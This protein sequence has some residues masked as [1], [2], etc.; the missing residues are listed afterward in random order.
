MPADIILRNDLSEMEVEERA[1][2]SSEAER[3]SIDC[4]LPE[5]TIGLEPSI[6]QQIGKGRVKWSKNRL[7]AQDR[8]KTN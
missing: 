3:E 7:P 6:H 5:D 2:V 4:A 8:M 1:E